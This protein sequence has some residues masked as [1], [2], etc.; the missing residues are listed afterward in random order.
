MGGKRKAQRILKPRRGRII[1]KRDHGKIKR[2]KDPQIPS[3]TNKKKEKREDWD[4]S[5]ERRQEKKRT[6]NASDLSWHRQQKG[7]GKPGQGRK[8]GNE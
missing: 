7:L 1:P 8:N 5:V 3:S 2:N 6:R 4:R